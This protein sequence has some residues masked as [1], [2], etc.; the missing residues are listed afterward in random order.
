MKIYINVD[1]TKGWDTWNNMAE[2]LNSDMKS[3]AGMKFIY[4][5]CDMDEKKHF[6][7]KVKYAIIVY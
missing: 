4:K 2:D 5:G 3:V 1:I 6:C 7:S